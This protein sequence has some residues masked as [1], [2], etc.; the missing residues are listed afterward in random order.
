MKLKNEVLVGI[1]VVLGLL[2]MMVGGIWLTGRPWGEEQRQVV[3]AFSEVGLLA[4]GSPVKY[5]GVRIGRV[6]KINLAE[7]GNGVFATLSVDPR[8]TLPPDAAVVL[9]AESFFG[10]WQA[11][12][13]SRGAV[14]VRE[15]AW[16]TAP[17][18]GVLP[19]A[20]MPDI[21]QLTAV[22][23][24][25]AGDIEL[26]SD[27][28]QLAFTEETAVQIRETIENVQGVSEQL[29]G[30][31]DQ[32]TDVYAAAGRNVLAA[33]GNVRD[34]TATAERVMTDVGRQFNQGDVQQILSNARLASENLRQ[35]SEQL[36][37]A[38]A[39][40]PG[41]V[42]RADT[43]LAAFGGLARSLEPQVA[44]LGPTLAQARAAM[45]TL[46]RAAARM[47]EGNGTLGRLM[48]D[49]ALYEET[50]RAVATLQR[51]LADIQ[52][53]PGKYIGQFKVF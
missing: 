50:Q 46:Q 42:T 2:V 53:N 31:I 21:T 14:E 19:G 45:E 9:S 7:R 34:A 22:A 13:V 3:A 49:P 33:T 44:E 23:A 29:S 1:T 43:T 30:F 4:E 51:F 38:G 24:R 47:E 6:E 8:V 18:R 12:I 35:F 32:Q 36:E 48:A 15:L 25:I 11:A 10:D 37:S 20:T 28:V 16:S 26:L 17:R 40:V 52:A 39:G 5:R 41:L 27:R